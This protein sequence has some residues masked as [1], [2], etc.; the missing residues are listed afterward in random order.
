MRAFASSLV[1]VHVL[2]PLVDSYT[3]THIHSSTD[4]HTHTHTVCGEHEFCA[5]LYR[6]R[7][8]IFLSYSLWKTIFSKTIF[9][10]FTANRRNN[11]LSQTKFRT[12]LVWLTQWPQQ[13]R[14]LNLKFTNLIENWERLATWDMSNQIV[15][16][17]Y[18]KRI[19]MLILFYI[20]YFFVMTSLCIQ[21]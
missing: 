10:P 19:T 3:R 4:T 21:A 8:C 17:N 15:H 20:L 5:F 18:T 7:V 13:S 2:T 9:V 11:F 1:A 14:K 12:Q 6:E 16:H